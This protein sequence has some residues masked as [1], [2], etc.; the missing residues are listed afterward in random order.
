MFWVELHKMK[1]G[2]QQIYSGTS[3]KPVSAEVLQ[4]C[5]ILKHADSDVTKHELTLAPALRD[6]SVR[7]FFF[8]STISPKGD[9]MT[10]FES[11][12]QL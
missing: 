11:A 3:D 12:S 10:Q 6:I 4:K 2:G 9:R 7:S 5:P 8:L 1:A